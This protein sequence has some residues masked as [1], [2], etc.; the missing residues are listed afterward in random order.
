VARRGGRSPVRVRYLPVVHPPPAGPQRRAAVRE[1]GRSVRASMV[2]ELE[3]LRALPRT[4][5]SAGR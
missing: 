2:A 1:L 4:R 3:R 5:S